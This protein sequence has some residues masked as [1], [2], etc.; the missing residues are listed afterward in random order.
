MSRSKD[1]SLF[2]IRNPKGKVIKAHESASAAL[3][4]SEG[5]LREDLYLIPECL[6]LIKG[7]H[8]RPHPGDVISVEAPSEPRIGVSNIN[9]M[10]ERPRSSPSNRYRDGRV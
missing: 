10:D 4:C 1:S 7:Q 8:V 2:T 6:P 5:D 3:Y 9:A